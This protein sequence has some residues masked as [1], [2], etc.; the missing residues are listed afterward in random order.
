MKFM[1]KIG[2]GEVSIH[3]N[4]VIENTPVSRS[5]DAWVDDFKLQQQPSTKVSAI[6]VII[7][8]INSR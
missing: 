1:K 6:T 4:Q 8:T 3:D 2:D 7:N 5:A